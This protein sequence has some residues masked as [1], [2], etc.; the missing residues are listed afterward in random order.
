M[1]QKTQKIKLAHKTLNTFEK[2]KI[3]TFFGTTT[4]DYATSINNSDKSSRSI[5]FSKN[6]TRILFCSVDLIRKN[7]F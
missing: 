1:R 4:I 2:R 5:N 6:N 7:N 3:K